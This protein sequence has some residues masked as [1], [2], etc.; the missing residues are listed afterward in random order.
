M[1]SGWT[2]IP[3]YEDL[4]LINKKA[5][6]FSL[7]SNRLLTPYNW[8]GYITVGLTKNRKTLTLGIH[9]LMARTFIPNPLHKI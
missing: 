4:Y 8:E 7:I 6:I 3:G 9:R 5:E 1:N 2:K